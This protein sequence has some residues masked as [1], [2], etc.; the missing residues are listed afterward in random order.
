MAA[1]SILIVV[2]IIYH[3]GDIDQRKMTLNKKLLS[4]NVKK[5]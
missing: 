1:I 3:E 4:L 5:Y 2:L